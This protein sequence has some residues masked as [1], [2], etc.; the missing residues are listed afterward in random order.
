VG[1]ADGAA[2]LGGF[3]VWVTGETRKGRSGSGSGSSILTFFHS[4]QS[5]R[6]EL[7]LYKWETYMAGVMN[8]V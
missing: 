4:R 2:Y 5:A 6:K 1:G 7:A 3:G 8:D